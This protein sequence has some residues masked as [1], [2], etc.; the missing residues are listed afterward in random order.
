MITKDEILILLGVIKL[1]YPKT[2]NNPN[3]K[4]TAALWHE[5]LC[6]EPLT[7]VQLA[8]KKHIASSIYPPTIAAVLDLVE[9]QK[10]EMYQEYQYICDVETGRVKGNLPKEYYP[11][12]VSGD[13]KRYE[14]NF[15]YKITNEISSKIQKMIESKGGIDGKL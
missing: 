9:K 10:W 14:S 2:F 5:M 4:Q 15:K 1:A 12:R 6:D 7:L 8:V 3:P 13:V 11:R